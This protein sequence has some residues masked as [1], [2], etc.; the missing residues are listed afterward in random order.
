LRRHKAGRIFRQLI[1]DGRAMDT[2]DHNRILDQAFGPN[3]P[4]NELRLSSSDISILKSASADADGLWNGGQSREASFKHGM[5]GWFQSPEEAR[6]KS[7]VW[8]EYCLN[9]AT[10]LQRGGSRGAALF[11]LGLGIHTIADGLSPTHSGFQ[12]WGGD[13]ILNI[14]G[15]AIHHVLEKPTG[16]VMDEAVA[17]VR[18]YYLEFRRR[19]GLDAGKQ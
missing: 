12:R 8:L 19:A 3:A 9:L 11:R 1:G 4:R 7:K 6:A 18:L 15:A 13:F 10:D 2:N 17:Y 16:M 5:R 14:P